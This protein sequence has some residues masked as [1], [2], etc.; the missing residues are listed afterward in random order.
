M[1]WI[2]C[3][4]PERQQKCDT[5]SYNE[6]RLYIDIERHLNICQSSISHSQ[7]HE[8]SLLEEFDAKNTKL[9]I[10]RFHEH[11]IIFRH[12]FL[13]SPHYHWGSRNFLPYTWTKI[14]R[15]CSCIIE[16]SQAQVA[17]CR[18]TRFKCEGTSCLTEHS[19]T[20][21]ISPRIHVYPCMVYSHNTRVSPTQG[22][23]FR[24]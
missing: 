15:I 20:F 22:L 2:V 7:L 5:F 14:W 23:G 9:K 1:L 24:V 18:G 4:K 3:G 10:H 12:G 11:F 8:K 21:I 19:Y 16:A 6:N 17:C 13:V